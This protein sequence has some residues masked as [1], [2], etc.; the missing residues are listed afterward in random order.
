MHYQRWRRAERERTGVGKVGRPREYPR[1][2]ADP[3]RGAPRLTVRLEPDVLEWARAQ[4]GGGWLR[5]V[6]RQLREWSTLPEF[7]AWWR[8]LEA[9]EDKEA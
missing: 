3:A 2:T 1:D 6:C 9:P 8:A 4:G 5:H 7:E